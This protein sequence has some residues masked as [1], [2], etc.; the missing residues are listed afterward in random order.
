MIVPAASYTY[1]ASAIILLPLSIIS[2]L[3]IYKGSKSHFAYILLAFTFADALIDFAN[4]LTDL[5]CLGIQITDS[6]G[7]TYLWLN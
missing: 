7:Q 4:Y 5:D 2:L 3:K 1:L 6:N